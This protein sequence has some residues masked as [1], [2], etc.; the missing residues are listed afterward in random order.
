MSLSLICI[1][2]TLFFSMSSFAGPSSVSFIEPKDGATVEENFKV[3]MNLQGMKLCPANIETKETDCGHHH[4]LIDTAAIPA[5][6][7]IT[8]DPKHL[9]FGKMQTETE[10]KL[11]P[12][13]HTLTLQF[14]D[15]A[16]R[17]YGEKMSATIHVEVKAKK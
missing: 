13:K 15:F 1:G 10:L 9:H 4:I 11:S 17:S 6:Q 8:N 14:A 7:V 5:N 3:K 16:H 12:G 2:L